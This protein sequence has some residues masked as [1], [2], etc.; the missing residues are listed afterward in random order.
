MACRRYYEGFY[1]PGCPC[2]TC[3]LNPKNTPSP[4]SRAEI[5]LGA[6]AGAAF[7]VLVIISLVVVA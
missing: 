3:R 6:I 7:A 2:D 5:T 4:L 1:C